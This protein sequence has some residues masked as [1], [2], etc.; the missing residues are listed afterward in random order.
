MRLLKYLAKALNHCPVSNLKYHPKI[1]K[2][3]LCEFINSTPYEGPKMNGKKINKLIFISVLF[4]MGIF[5]TNE[6]VMGQNWLPVGQS[7]N[8]KFYVDSNSIKKVSS[9]SKRVWTKFI[10][11]PEE[12][13]KSRINNNLPIN[14]YSSFS[15]GLTYCEINCV[16]KFYLTLSVVDYDNNGKPLEQI[17]YKDPSKSFIIPGSIFDLIYKAI[18]P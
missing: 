13:I 3:S 11:S 2:T 15:Y 7:N 8:W 1:C 4:V 18:C 5:L 10:C 17:N 12:M 6:N 16:E 14:G 9:T